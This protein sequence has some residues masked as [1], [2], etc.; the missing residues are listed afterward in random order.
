MKTSLPGTYLAF[1]SHL[2]TVDTLL[3]STTDAMPS[4]STQSFL[5]GLY[6]NIKAR[7]MVEGVFYC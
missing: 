2:G 5:P 4:A 3:A 7:Q 1:L 6:L